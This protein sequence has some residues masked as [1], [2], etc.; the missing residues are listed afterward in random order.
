MH[1]FSQGDGPFFEEVGQAALRE[2]LNI[3]H[4]T[5]S[6]DVVVKPNAFFGCL[7]LEVIAASVVFVL[8]TGDR[9]GIGD[10]KDATVAIT[11]FLK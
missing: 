3:C 2:A 11:R 4:V 5:F 8:D 7:S 9:Y 10:V 1:E 6:P